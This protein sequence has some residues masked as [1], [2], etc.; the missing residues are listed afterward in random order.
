MA[1]LE[2]KEEQVLRWPDGVDRTFIKLRKENK[3]WKKTWKQLVPALAEELER[4]GAT[5][6]ILICRS[7]DERKD[8]GV[9]VWFSMKKV[10][11]EWQ[12]GLDLPNP[13]PT[14]DQIS[15]AFQAKAKRFHPDTP[16]TGDP[17]MFKKLTEH[18][19]A[20]MAWITGSHAHSRESVMAIDQYTE[21][22][23]NLCAIRLAFGHIRGLERVGA[24]GIISQTLGA[25]RAKL[26]ATT[27]GSDATTAT[28]R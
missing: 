16:V 22:R 18:R 1:K 9:A 6:S 13:A 25:F 4:L 26:V 8:P 3:A 21:A 5:G 7:D 28:Q 23:L 2:V 20:A 24:P 19:D 15:K 17:E 10:S 27:G 14:P 11:F 12:Q